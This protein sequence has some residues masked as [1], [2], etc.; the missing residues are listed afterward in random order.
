MSIEEKD[1]IDAIVQHVKYCDLDEL[2]RIAA[3]LFG[4]TYALIEVPVK[5]STYF[6]TKF[7]FELTPNEFYRGQFDRLK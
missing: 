1:L 6:S 4:G 5:G 2:A 3:Y 7:C